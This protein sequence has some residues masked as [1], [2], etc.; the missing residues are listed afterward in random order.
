MNANQTLEDLKTKDL[1]ELCLMHGKQKDKLVAAVIMLEI[2]ERNDV[3]FNAF[4]KNG[5]ITGKR[6]WKLICEHEER[7]MW[8]KFVPA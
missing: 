5:R 3:A 4:L 7:S 2:V 1:A 8:A 6:I